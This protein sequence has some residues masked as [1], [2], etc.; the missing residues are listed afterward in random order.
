[1]GSVAIGVAPT[2]GESTKDDARLV[3]EGVSTKDVPGS[4]GSA[5]S[6]S[7]PLDVGRESSN[8]IAVRVDSEGPQEARFAPMKTMNKIAPNDDEDILNLTTA[9]A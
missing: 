2:D 7:F 5:A 6:T 9:G 3:V 8:P 1:M 4:K